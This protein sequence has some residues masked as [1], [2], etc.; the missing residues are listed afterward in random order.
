MPRY[1]SKLSTI[2]EHLELMKVV[3]SLRFAVD[4]AAL[5]LKAAHSRPARAHGP[6]QAAADQYPPSC[7]RS[8]RSCSGP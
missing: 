7:H 4:N 3:L 5:P 2:N 6:P 8:C 1:S